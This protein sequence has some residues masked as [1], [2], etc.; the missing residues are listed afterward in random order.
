MLLRAYVPFFPFPILFIYAICIFW[1]IVPNVYFYFFSFFKDLSLSLLFFSCISGFIFY[2]FSVLYCFLFLL[3]LVTLIAFN[4]LCL[5]YYSLTNSFLLVVGWIIYSPNPYVE[6]LCPN[7]PN[8]T[9]LEDKA[10]KVMIKLKWVQYG[11]P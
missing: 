10:F 11:G 6:T 7:T 9:P 3:I 8:V 4:Y 5:T 2:W 1:T